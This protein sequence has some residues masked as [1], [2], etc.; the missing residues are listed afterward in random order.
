VPG[1]WP[2][3]LMVWCFYGE[4]YLFGQSWSGP[5]E[6]GVGLALPFGVPVCFT[7]TG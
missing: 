6:R 5:R 2:A 7:L 4:E 3:W 1:S